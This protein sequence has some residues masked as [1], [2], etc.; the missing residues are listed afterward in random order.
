[1]VTKVLTMIYSVFV[2]AYSQ[3]FVA[4]SIKQGNVWEYEKKRSENYTN[5]LDSTYPS[6]QITVKVD[7]VASS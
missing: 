1:M 6:A 5:V 3:V 4:T 2:F 7:S